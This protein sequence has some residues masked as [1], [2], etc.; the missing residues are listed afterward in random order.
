MTTKKKPPWLRIRVPQEPCLKEMKKLLDGLNLHTVCESALCP[1]ITS[2][3]SERTATFMI[4]GDVCTRNCKFCNIKQGITSPPDPTE[5]Q[6]VAQAAKMLKLKHLVVTSVT[7]DDLPDGGAFFFAETVRQTNHLSPETSTELLI[8]D[9]GGLKQNV[10]T[11]VEAK[12]DIIA[13]NIDTI[14]RLYAKVKPQS[15][16][17]RSLSVLRD[18]KEMNPQ[19]ITKSGIMVGLG[20]RRE[21]ILGTMYDLREAGCDILTIGQ[22]LRPTPQ[23]VEVEEFIHP[24]V[25]EQHKKYGHS[26][27][28][29][30][31]ASSPLVRSSFDAYHALQYFS[32]KRSFSLSNRPLNKGEAEITQRGHFQSQ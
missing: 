18:A 14:P 10:Y 32:E 28:F 16:Y 2:C 30:Y 19:S 31:V 20:E 7:R 26:M 24:E 23:N 29:K 25:F 8:S 13:H 22:Y 6:R 21:E 4:L 12:P 3:F 5:P 15:S 27:G 11:V 1:N 17:S 9:L